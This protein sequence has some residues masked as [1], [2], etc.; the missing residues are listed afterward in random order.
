[1]LQI[2]SCCAQSCVCVF[3]FCFLKKDK[4]RGEM[5]LTYASFVFTRRAPWC[6]LV[7]K[8]QHVCD[9]SKRRCFKRKK[10]EESKAVLYPPACQHFQGCTGWRSHGRDV[11]IADCCVCDQSSVQWSER[12]ERIMPLRV[13]SLSSRYPPR[14]AALFPSPQ[15]M[16][17]CASG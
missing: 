6:R 11:Y 12:G 14:V 2:G 9:V 4:L 16:T 5:F 15:E 7:S 10:E 1:M 17:R 3:V 8:V 13:S